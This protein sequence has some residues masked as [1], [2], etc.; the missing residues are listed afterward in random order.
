MAPTV[1]EEMEV[2]R[3]AVEGVRGLVERKD[4]MVNGDGP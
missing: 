2:V 4:G 3:A 1:E